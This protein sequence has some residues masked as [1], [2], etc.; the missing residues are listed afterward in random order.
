MSKKKTLNKRNPI[1]KAMAAVP[2]RF[3]TKAFKKSDK[4]SWDRKTKHKNK[5]ID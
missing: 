3:S 5:I 2:H 4:D 1:A